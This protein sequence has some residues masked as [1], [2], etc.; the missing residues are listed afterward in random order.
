MAWFDCPYHWLHKKCKPLRDMFQKQNRHYALNNLGV[1]EIDGWI[2]SLGVSLTDDF[3][4]VVHPY[5][6]T[7][8]QSKHR[9]SVSASKR[10]QLP[11][12][13]VRY[14]G[15]LNTVTAMEAGSLVD[16]ARSILA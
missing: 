7:A 3:H 11:K 12:K 1:A 15:S 8:A 4:A 16:A 14:S 9:Q 10:S 6:Y 5:S 2:I 13:I